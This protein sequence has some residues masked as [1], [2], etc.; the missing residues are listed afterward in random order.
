V[1]ERKAL[2]VTAVVVQ[3]SQAE[4]QTLEQLTRAAVVAVTSMLHLM[5]VVQVARELSLFAA[6][7]RLRQQQD[8]QQFL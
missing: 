2:V 5:P 1:V 7:L 4:Q 8:H 6:Y 3:V